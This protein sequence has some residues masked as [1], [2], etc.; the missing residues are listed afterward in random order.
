MP[1][2]TVNT[3]K[4]RKNAETIVKLAAKQNIKVT[5]VT[6]VSCGSPKIAKAMLEG[7]VSSIGDSRLENIHR[8][9]KAGIKTEFMLLREPRQ[10]EAKKVVQLA[11]ISLNTELETMKKLS[12]VL[13]KEQ[14]HKVIIMVE[15]GDLREGVEPQ[16]L[17]EL[18][19]QTLKL[20][21]I[22][23]H[24]LGMNLECF[25]GVVPTKKKIDKFNRIIEETQKKH[26]IKLETISGGNSANIPLLLEG[27]DHGNINNLRIGEGILLGVESV[28][29][30][31]I[32]RTYQD[33]FIIEAELIEIEEKDS[34]P[35]DKTAQTAFGKKRKLKDEGRMNRGLI[36]LGLQDT[37]ANGLTPL[38]KDIQVIGG[39]SDSI[40]LDMNETEYKLGDKIQF[41]PNY[42]ALLAA[43]TSPYVDKEFQQS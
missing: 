30:T 38:D 13:K 21:G 41:I 37:R 35:T 15:M 42:G 7:R 3:E 28:N 9:K 40:V 6:K 8:L 16:K 14:E 29:R 5:G 26:G 12:S 11:D 23:L 36:A 32:P 34:A 25:A 27:T 10:S 2:L 33:A 20:K 22:N 43:F 39:T 18:I 19:E 17:D 31:P 4:I 24:G 1:K